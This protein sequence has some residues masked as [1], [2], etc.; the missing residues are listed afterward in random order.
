MTTGWMRVIIMEIEKIMVRRV[1][2]IRFAEEYGV[3]GN[4][5]NQR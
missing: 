2:Q 5:K 4:L 3:W 1:E